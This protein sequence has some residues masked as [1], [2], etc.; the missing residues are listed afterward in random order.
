MKILAYKG[1]SIPSRLIRLQTRSEYSHVA[2]QM[3]D[4]TVIEAW[5]I[6]G[7]R[8]VASPTEAHKPGTPIDVF[9]IKGT[10]DEGMVRRFL[11][12]Q[13]GKRYDYRAIVR[14]LTRRKMRADDRW[15]CSEL[16]IEAFRR[17]GLHL[18]AR[19]PASYAPPRDVAMSPYC[20]GPIN[21]A[22]ERS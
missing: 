2:V 9:E 20:H 10:Y 7:V 8:H 11:K 5:A 3:D 18:Q 13:L 15:F 21:G 17:G 16:V 19:I 14:F 1:R 12:S 22:D 4:G 6:G